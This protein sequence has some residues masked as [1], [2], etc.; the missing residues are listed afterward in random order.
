LLTLVSN[1]TLINRGVQ[2]S[3]LPSGV[4]VNKHYYF[5]VTDVLTEIGS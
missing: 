4:N 1:V 5:L 2:T 3:L